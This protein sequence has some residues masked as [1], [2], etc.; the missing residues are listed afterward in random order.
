MPVFTYIP[1]QVSFMHLLLTR[2][3]SRDDTAS[4]VEEGSQQEDEHRGPSEIKK[5]RKKDK[6]K[7]L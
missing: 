1:G 2:V 3:S 7:K 4:L 5:N 6:K